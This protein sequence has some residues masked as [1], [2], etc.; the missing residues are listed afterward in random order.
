MALVTKVSVGVIGYAL[1]FKVNFIC[2]PSC[3]FLL[4]IIF[5]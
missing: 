3:D 1:C 4:L 2:C 5:F